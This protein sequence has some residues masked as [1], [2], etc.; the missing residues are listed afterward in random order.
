MNR[1]KTIAQSCLYLEAMDRLTRLIINPRAMTGKN[2][3]RI[4]RACN[5]LCFSSFCHVYRAIEQSFSQHVFHAWECHPLACKKLSLDMGDDS[6]YLLRC[7]KSTGLPG[8]GR[9]RQSIPE[10]QQPPIQLFLLD[11]PLASLQFL[12]LLGGRGSAWDH[13]FACCH[14]TSAG[15][16]CYFRSF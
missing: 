15:L 6:S 14:K 16:L 1:L 12:Q 7:G 11:S 2:C 13:P 8:C 4:V 3:R 5:C 9:Q 10:L